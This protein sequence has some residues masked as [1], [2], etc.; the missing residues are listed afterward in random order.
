MITCH[1]TFVSASLS[2]DWTFIRGL[3]LNSIYGGRMDNTFDIEILGSYLREFFNESA[4][5]RGLFGPNLSLPS[6]ESYSEYLQMIHQLN[7][8]DKPSLFGLPENIERS[9]Q[10]MKSSETVNQL[11]GEF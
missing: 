3:L 9:W 4:L 2:I 10:K 7:D 11:K 8:F 1:F 6:S 5:N